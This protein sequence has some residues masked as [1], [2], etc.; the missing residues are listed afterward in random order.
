VAHQVGR[1]GSRSR[2]DA[3]ASLTEYA[4]GFSLVVVASLVAVQFLT[5]AAQQE[6]AN[7]ADCISSRPPPASCVRQPVPA[8]TTSSPTSSVPTSSTSSPPPT[9][10]PSTTAPP[11]TVPPPSSTITGGSGTAT[12]NAN[13]LTWDVAA[14]VTLADDQGQPVAD[15]VVSGVVTIGRQPFAVSCTTDAAGGCTLT[16]VDIDNGIDGLS[17]TVTRVESQPP[18]APP[19]PPTLTF[20]RP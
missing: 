9:D 13:G 10:P 15:A 7:Q 14:P 2:A 8:T 18:T 20:S 1:R 4:V 17:L 12:A 16:F 11:T 19:Y 6:S 3:G 5:R